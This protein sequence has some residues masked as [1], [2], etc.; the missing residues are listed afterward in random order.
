MLNPIAS[1]AIYLVETLIAYVY[2]S[3]FLEQKRPAWQCLLLG[4]LS[5]AG[6]SALNLL[7][8]NNTVLNLCTSFLAPF[9]FALSCYRGKLPL[10]AFYALIFAVLGGTIETAVVA[11]GATITGN[12]FLDYN[13]NTPLFLLEAISCKGL[14]LLAV[15]IAVRFLNPN[16][17]AVKVPPAFL[18]Y[19]M[20]GTFCIFIF[21]RVCAQADCTPENQIFLAAAAIGLFL[22]SILL[23]ATYSRQ[24]EKDREAIQMR[25]ELSRLQT[26]RSYYEIQNQQNHQLMLYAHDAKNHLAAIQALNQ[27]PRIDHYLAQLSQQLK[28]YTRNCH[29]GNQLL[30]VMIH[31]YIITCELRNIRFE[32]DIRSCNLS[33]LADI[34]LVAILG[35]LMDNAVSA[36]EQSE[37]K[38][39]SLSTSHRNSY[40]VIDLTNSCDAPPVQRGDRLLSTKTD[41]LS[42]GFGMKSVEKAIR[43]YQGDFSWNYHADEKRFTATVMLTDSP[44]TAGAQQPV[45]L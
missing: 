39:I 6:A 13:N 30:D 25:A 44:A 19:P 34:D 45:E 12:G 42:H 37:E 31:K 32:Y 24:T 26:E 36:A 11:F 23:F 28:D 7:F 9:L 35:N 43:S 14:T 38:Y 29:S 8:R 22:S 5:F 21:W 17:N 16:K 41:K 40:S 4:G 1:F 3:G 18:I 20:I 27:D 33:Q 10:K 2:Y 15:L